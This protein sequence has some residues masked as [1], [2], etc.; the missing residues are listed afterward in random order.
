MGSQLLQSFDCANAV[1]AAFSDASKY[2]NRWA[3]CSSNSAPMDIT[4]A[5][6]IS[7]SL[8][9][10]STTHFGQATP[11][12]ERSPADSPRE[13]REGSIPAEDIVN[14]SL[15]PLAEQA[16]LISPPQ[17]TQQMRSLP[18][19]E[20]PRLKR[21]S[22]SRQAPPTETQ[23]SV[24]TRERE[25]ATAIPQPLNRKR[26]RPKSRPKMMEAY[27]A[28]DLLF[29][30]SSSRQS[31]LEKNRVAAHKCRRRKKDYMDSLEGRAREFS[32][33]NKVLK[34]N[35]AL[36][37]EEVLRLKH[38]VLQHAGCGF[39]A[40]DEYLA[41]CAGH[42]LGMKDP[43]GSRANLMHHQPIRPRKNSNEFA[44]SPG[45]VSLA[46]DADDF[47]G[48]EVLLKDYGGELDIQQ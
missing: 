5:F 35:V 2:Q 36:L 1:Y 7:P 38:G 33:K 43:H 11:P 23:A 22:I 26:G 46:H 29:Q 3:A 19:N 27:T 14:E 34:E 18:E 9:T 13:A 30:V 47:G 32:G 28:E 42:L 16:Y 15:W 41:Q 45:S 8:L 12:E 37:R 4:T 17:N 24:P 21:R 40:V 39:W 31:N 10:H 25:D 6:T 48:L 44:L 20:K